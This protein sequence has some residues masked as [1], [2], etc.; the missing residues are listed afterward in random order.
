MTVTS[1]PRTHRKTIGPPLPSPANNDNDDN[2]YSSAMLDIIQTSSPTQH[3][4]APPASSTFLALLPPDS[5]IS[6]FTS[7]AAV[8]NSPS[9]ES[10]SLSPGKRPRD[11]MFASLSANSL[12]ASQSLLARN[13]DIERFLAN[14]L[15]ENLAKGYMSRATILKVL[16]EPEMPVENYLNMDDSMSIDRDIIFGTTSLITII[17]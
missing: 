11:E 7:F 8:A 6:D 9:T 10:S 3:I 12:R 13:S 5:I 2:D 16:D 15:A 4:K 14:Q 17:T 1:T